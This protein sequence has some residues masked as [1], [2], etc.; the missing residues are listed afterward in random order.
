MA[1]DGQHFYYVNPLEADPKARKNPD[2]KH[3]LTRRQGWFMVACCPSN[4]ARLITSVNRYIYTQIP[5]GTI[6]S[7]QF[8]ASK[9]EFANGFK[10]RQ[11]GNFP[12]SGDISWRLTN[13]SRE[14]QAQRFAIRIPGWSA[15]SF[16]L[17]VDGEPVV[18][19]QVRDGFVYFN[20]DAGAE[21]RIELHL[22]MSVRAVR[23]NN[24]VAA[25]EGKVAIMRGP[26]VYCAEQADNPEDLWRYRITTNDFEYKFEPELLD[27]VGVIK[28][29]AEFARSDSDGLTLYLPDDSQQ[30]YSTQMQLV[31]YYS[32][33][34]RE[35]GQM[36]VWLNK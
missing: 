8:I 27:G 30:W 4:L 22:D 34:N 1:L 3:V 24:H 29:R 36:R 33:A 14:S 31:P 5:D 15:N 17:S 6:L 2:R 23:A 18:S 21:M 26:L 12:W 25:D 32:W 9:A 35:E 10:V 28:A 16:E 13:A 11:E 20:V 7:H 19:P